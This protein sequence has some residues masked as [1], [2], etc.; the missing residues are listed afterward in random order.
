MRGGR[1]EGPSD[2]RDTQE[3]FGGEKT[4]NFSACVNGISGED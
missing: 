3:F 2:H 4:G 1:E